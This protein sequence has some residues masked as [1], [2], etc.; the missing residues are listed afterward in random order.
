[1]SSKVQELLKGFSAIVPINVAW[2]EM[3]ALGHVNNIIY[4]RYFETSRIEFCSLL[5][6]PGFTNVGSINS[7]SALGPILAAINC[8]YKFP[9]TFPDTLYSAS[10]VKHDGIHEYGFDVE[11]RLVSKQHERIAAEGTASIVIYNFLARKKEKMPDEIKQRL[12]A[13]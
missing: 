1:M 12:Q 6:Y 5:Q 4:L 11:H 10:R 3:D 7:Q 13:L 9:V 2:G 8:K